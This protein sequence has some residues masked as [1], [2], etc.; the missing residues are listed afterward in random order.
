[1][2]LTRRKDSF[3]IEFP[4]IDDGKTLTLAR[5]IDA[6][7]LKRWNLCIGVL[8]MA[9]GLRVNRKRVHQ[10]YRLEG[11]QLRMRIRRRKHKALH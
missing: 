3:Y 9:R 7:R 2:G 8:F 4:V 5:G 10:L 6:A 1:M 11:L